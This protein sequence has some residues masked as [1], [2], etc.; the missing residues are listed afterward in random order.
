M[1][2]ENQIVNCEINPVRIKIM[3]KSVTVRNRIVKML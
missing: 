1:S 2:V 3:M